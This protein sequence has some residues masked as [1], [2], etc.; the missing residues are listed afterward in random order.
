VFESVEVTPFRIA[1]LAI[2]GLAILHTL[3]AR[4]F[5]LIAD[6][7][8]TNKAKKESHFSVEIFRFLGEVEVVFALWVIP[9]MC[10]IFSFYNWPTAIH[11]LNTRSFLEPLLVVVVMSIAAS[12]PIIRIT[13][14]GMWLIAQVFGGSVAAWWMTILTL[15]PILG[16]FITE[17]GAMTISA[18]LLI[19]MFYVYKPSRA[20]SYATLGLL[21][22]NISVGGLLTN[23]AAA[24]VLI[25][26]RTWEWDTWYMLTQ[27]GWK[28][29]V[30]ILISNILYYVYFRKELAALGKVS[31][32][33]PA[34]E[35]NPPPLWVTLV[36]MI[37][38]IGV[39]M[40]AHSPIVFIGLFLLFLGFHQATLTYQTPIQLK[41]PLL[42]GMFL[43]G[44]VI[45]GG[46]QGWW[47]EPALK[48]LTDGTVM[49]VVMAL[50]PFNDNAAITYLATLSPHLAPEVKYAIVSGVIAGG[51]LTVIA[52]APNP[53]GQSLL[54]RFF[55]GGIS[56]L[57]L[58]LAA[59]VPTV[60]LVLLFYF[61]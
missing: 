60:V 24:P 48:D 51:G 9:L 23:F 50:T 57:Y 17:V 29:V 20:L 40:N 33:G 30:G 54:K 55:R 21:F 12:R 38:L 10:V 5:N 13:E 59:A 39:V 32:V 11:Y 22:V 44:L 4:R 34:R 26:A 36:Q 52:N 46:L 45:H 25:V 15:G 61:F 28:A 1:T 31:T 49:L 56:P 53:A 37:F 14:G 18:L 58:F 19:R 42:V 3:F 6:N 41:R 27:F 43:A 8:A 35:A 16:S 47:I 2:F 7:L